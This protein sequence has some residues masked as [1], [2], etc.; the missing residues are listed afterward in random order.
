MKVS[1]L[2][3]RLVRSMGRWEPIEEA[4]RVMDE[5][6][7]D[8]LTIL[9]N[10]RL[11]GLVTRR[12]ISL[13]GIGRGLSLQEPVATIMTRDLQTCDGEMETED[14]FDIMT[15][16]QIRRMPVCNPYGRLIGMISLE[17][18]ASSGS[19]SEDPPDRATVLTSFA[20]SG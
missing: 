8:A 12:D 9:D 10:G 15:A 19:Q 3:T 1:S 11:V 7:V 17:I 16:Q 6:N 18:L 5:A 4:A 13:R 2:M 14:A 20:S